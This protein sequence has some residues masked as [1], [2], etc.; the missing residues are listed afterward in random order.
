MPVASDLSHRGSG[1][2]ARAYARLDIEQ[3]GRGLAHSREV[4]AAPPAPVTLE[5]VGDFL[6]LDL[7]RLFVWLRA[8]FPLILFLAALGAGLGGAYSMWAKP[9]YVV[10]TDILIDPAKLQVVGDDLFSAQGQ[11]DTQVINVG[12]KVRV[13][14]SGNVLERVVDELDLVNDPEFF[15]PTPSVGFAGLFDGTVEPAGDGRLAATKA[16]RE[17]ITTRSDDK[18]FVVTLSV[19]AQSTDK[20]IL[21]SDA[22][23]RAFQAELAVAEANSAGEAASTL[24][25]R[26]GELKSDVLLAEERV[27]NYKRD[28]NLASSGGQLVSSQA[29]TQLNTELVAAQSRAVAAQANYDMLLS[30][31]ANVGADSTLSAT[32]ITLRE[33]AATVQQELDSQ[34]VIYGPR[35]PSIVSLSAEIAAVN[36]QLETE[37][38]R[39]IATVKTELDQNNAAVAALTARMDALKTDQFADNDL[40][41]ELRELERDAAAKAAIYENILSRT[42]QV[43]ELEQINTTNV[44]VISTATPPAGR[45]WPPRSAVLIMLGA[46][47]GFALGMV[48]ALALG[49]IRDMRRPSASSIRQDVTP[50]MQ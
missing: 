28:H 3:R 25:D 46:F 4:A 35:H 34:S 31:G 1:S 45:S 42:G 2:A 23:V 11:I 19:A 16:L 47:A 40:Q 10:T 38:N 20:A 14:T 9:S 26:L 18:S 27:E 29:M 30:A 7:R 8:G 33:K 36:S 50:A 39:I 37:L 24:G 13:L 49:M 43:N 5:K 44:R 12:S 41:V 21:L 6:E 32:L 15:D 22:M 48:L 17:R